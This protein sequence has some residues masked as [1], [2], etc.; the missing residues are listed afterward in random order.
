MNPWNEKMLDFPAEKIW[1]FRLQTSANTLRLKTTTWFCLCQT[2]L[3]ESIWLYIVQNTSRRI[4]FYTSYWGWTGLRESIW[5]IVQN[6]FRRILLYTSY[7]G[8]MGLLSI[9]LNE[10]EG[11]KRKTPFL[12]W[13]NGFSA[14]LWKNTFPPY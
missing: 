13:R 9:A 4:L 10:K 11:S 14:L 5:L 3:R 7:W 12:P 8:W 6:T 1:T 2:G